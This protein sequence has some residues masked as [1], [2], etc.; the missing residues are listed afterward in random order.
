MRILGLI[1]A[2]LVTLGC[3]NQRFPIPVETV[4]DEQYIVRVRIVSELNELNSPYFKPDRI[5]ELLNGANEKYKNTGIQFELSRL[6]GLSN[7][8]SWT[9]EKFR[10]DAVIYPEYLS[11]YL[12][13]TNIMTIQAWV[14]V[15]IVNGISSFPWE[16]DKYGVMLFNSGP[17]SK[18]TWAHEIGHWAGLYHTFEPFGDGVDDTPEGMGHDYC[19]IMNYNNCESGTFTSGQIARMRYYISH[20]RSEN[21]LNPK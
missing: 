1:L 7:I 2:L 13:V 19:N 20:N 4:F 12:N 8:T 16:T 17:Y 14:D 3:T 11:I 5:L 18:E 6:D 9:S 10:E 15:R 21:L